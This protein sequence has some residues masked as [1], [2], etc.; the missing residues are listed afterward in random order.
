MYLLSLAALKQ[1]K[2]M[3]FMLTCALN[4]PEV[5]MSVLIDRQMGNLPR[6]YTALR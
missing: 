1:S 3:K 6:M 5:W 2:D 4:C